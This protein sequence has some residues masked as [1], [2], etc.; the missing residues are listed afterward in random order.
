MAMTCSQLLQRTAANCVGP[1][2]VQMV[3]DSMDMGGSMDMGS[4]GL[5]R[6][7]RLRGRPARVLILPLVV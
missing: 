2:K 6:H 5:I 3:N 1:K 7:C 4:N